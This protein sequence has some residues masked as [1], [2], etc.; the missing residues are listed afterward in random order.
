MSV[1][2][3]MAEPGAYVYFLR[4]LTEALNLFATP[5]CLGSRKYAPTRGARELHSAHLLHRSY[6]KRR[7]APPAAVV[8]QAKQIAAEL[9]IAP[10]KTDP[11]AP[12]HLQS[13]PTDRISKKHV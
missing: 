1:S 5:A 7:I 4:V 9:R 11:T 12:E 13:K 10:L 8:S 6:P 2:S 3:G